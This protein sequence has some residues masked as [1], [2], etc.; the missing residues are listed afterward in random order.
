MKLKGSGLSLQKVQ[1]SFR[2]SSEASLGEGVYSAIRGK[3][4]ILSHPDVAHHV[5]LNNSGREQDSTTALTEV[6]RDFATDRIHKMGAREADAPT[7][8]RERE[9]EPADTTMRQCGA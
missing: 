3:L 8:P 9:R 2:S 4:F 7:G 1:N 6:V 5:Y